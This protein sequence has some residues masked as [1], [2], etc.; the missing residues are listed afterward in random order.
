M[1]AHNHHHAI[2]YLVVALLFGL[3]ST[4]STTIANDS[5]LDNYHTR[6]TPEGRQQAGKKG[7]YRKDTHVWVYTS[8]FAQRFGMPKQ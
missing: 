2:I 3:F 6:Y 7:T 1:L 8:A 5:Q 4:T